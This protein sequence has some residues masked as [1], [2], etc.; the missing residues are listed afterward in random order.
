MHYCSSHV[1]NLTDVIVDAIEEKGESLAVL[2]FLKV[3]V[4]IG[5]STYRV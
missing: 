2:E 1:R 5:W 3:G 4:H